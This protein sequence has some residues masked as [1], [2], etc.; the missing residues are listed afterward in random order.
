V[1]QSFTPSNWSARPFFPDAV[2]AAPDSVPALPFPDASAALEPEASLNAYAAT[3]PA[4][5]I[6][7]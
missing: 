7:V 4:G 6:S 2:Q 1:T 5:P 3:G